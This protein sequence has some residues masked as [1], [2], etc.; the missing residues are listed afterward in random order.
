M[1]DRAI[2]QGMNMKHLYKENQIIKQ[3]PDG[4]I[5][6]TAKKEDA[7]AFYEFNGHVHHD[8]GWEN[9]SEVVASFAKD[10]FVANHPT[11]TLGDILIVEDP[12]TNAIV[13]TCTLIPQ[14]WRYEE[15]EIQVG[16][17]EIV[18]SNPDY[19]KRGLI[20][21]QFE[22]LHKMSAYAGH[23]LQSITGI[24]FYYRLYG[25]EMTI[26][27]DG[28]GL[29]NLKAIPALKEDQQES[30]SLR[31]ATQNDY[32]Y[33]QKLYDEGS[34]RSLVSAVKDKDQWD[35]IQ[36]RA[37]PKS[38]A[39][40]DLAIIED[41]DHKPVGYIAYKYQEEANKTTLYHYEL[42]SNASWVEITPFLLRTFKKHFEE[43][44][45]ELKTIDFFFGNQHPSFDA[46]PHLFTNISST[47]TWFIRVEDIPAFLNTIKPVLERRLANSALRGYTGELKLC[48]YTDGVFIKF[49]Q[50]KITSIE[51]WIYTRQTDEGDAKFPY[52]SFLHILFGHKSFKEIS[53]FYADSYANKSKI[54][55]IN[56]LFPKQHNNIHPLT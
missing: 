56:T 30:Y 5:L 12:K 4:L 40:R 37:H 48:F 23:Q 25:Y 14:T 51:K 47:Y 6:R 35:Y 46:V 42:D 7:E 50:G 1:G 22:L 32:A 29:V 45:K 33:I 11:V 9:F 10:L 39:S 41:K 54:A 38:F 24:P 53:S 31:T 27:L 15:I 17:P 49:E 2:N 19:R 21:D 55:L 20:R 28:G 36:N 16:R 26:D 34:K 43:I 18:G 8:E 3:Y 44:E 52:L 13:S